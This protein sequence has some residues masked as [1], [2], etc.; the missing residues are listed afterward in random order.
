MVQAHVSDTR[1]LALAAAALLAGCG[2]ASPDR[3][4]QAATLVLDAAPSGIDAGLYL[5]L[6]R[7]FT[8][9]EGVALRVEPPSSAATPA[10]ALATARAQFAILDL[11]TLAR[12]RERGRDLVAVMAI[13]EQPLPSRIAE[14][15]VRALVRHRDPPPYPELVLAVTRT[16]LEENPALVRATVVS[17]QRGDREALADPESA[18]EAILNHTEGLDRAKLAAQM[19]A[20]QPALQASDGTIGTLD[21]GRLETWARWEARVGITKRAPDV[22]LAFEPRFARAGAK[23]AAE[24]SGS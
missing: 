14:R 10:T 2:G 15:R 5:A 1:L 11:H 18:V 22:A 9:A 12:A 7:D 4:N 6:E 23:Q 3:P 21:R 19:D 8:G 24:N 20:V 17:L 16:T 13:V